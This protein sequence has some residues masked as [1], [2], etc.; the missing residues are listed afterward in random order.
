MSQGLETLDLLA[1]HCPAHELSNAFRL[2]LP[3]PLPLI[4]NPKEIQASLLHARRAVKQR[5]TDSHFRWMTL[6]PRTT[7][8][9]T[10]HCSKN[11]DVAGASRTREQIM[12]WAAWKQI[13]LLV[14][15][16]KTTRWSTRVTKREHRR[17]DE[18][19]SSVVPTPRRW[20]SDRLRVWG[21]RLRKGLGLWPCGPALA[22]AGIW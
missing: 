8:L 2:F 10:M 18:A 15:R 3:C 19:L 7:Q 20:D 17:S 21:A 12:R 5:P 13:A 4:G 9:A 14:A 6:R 16:R 1:V 22:K 11:R